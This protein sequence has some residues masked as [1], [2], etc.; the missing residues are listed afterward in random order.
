MKEYT[1]GKPAPDE[2]QVV[3]FTVFLRL[4]YLLRLYN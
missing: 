2:H 1:L 4:S 3:L